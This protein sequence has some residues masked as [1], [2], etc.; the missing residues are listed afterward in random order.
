MHTRTHARALPAWRVGGEHHDFLTLASSSS[1]PFPI[2]LTNADTQP[3]PRFH[4][5]KTSKAWFISVEVSLAPSP[6]PTSDRPTDQPTATDR[7]TS[8]S[9]RPKDPR[10]YLYTAR[11]LHLT[12][13]QDEGRWNRTK[14]LEIPPLLFLLFLPLLPRA[15]LDATGPACQA[16]KELSPD[17]IL[18]GYGVPRFLWR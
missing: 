13:G 6:S 15:A 2:P 18:N 17:S 10:T 7:Q 1:L 16:L 11:G 14:C 9:R 5:G 8:L 12:T 4:D 3:N